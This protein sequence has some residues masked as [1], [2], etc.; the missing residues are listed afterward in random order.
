MKTL[1]RI[2]LQSYAEPTFIVTNDK[3]FGN[4]I[5]KPRL[6]VVIDTDNRGR[7]LVASVNHRTSKAVI[8]DK[9]PFRQV[10]ERKK[11][12]DRSEVYETKYIDGVKPLT[13]YDKK[14]IIEILRKK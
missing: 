6:G 4:G 5:D 8:L 1:Q 3:H 13:K 7:L 9:Q 11:W 2:D 14:K 10:D 12:I